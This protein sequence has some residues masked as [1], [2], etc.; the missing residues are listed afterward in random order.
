MEF[1]VKKA[2]II[3]SLEGILLK[4][5]GDDTSTP[6]FINALVPV[7]QTEEGLP[8][9]LQLYRY[10]ELG[11]LPEIVRLMIDDPKVGEAVRMATRF[12]DNLIPRMVEMGVT[13][14][15]RQ[16]ILEW[17]YPAKRFPQQWKHGDSKVDL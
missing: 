8:A 9:P 4:V 7:E 3:P 14:Y 5:E 2:V 6:R 13:A 11:Q 1:F 10:V 17:M 12:E 15:Q 16:V